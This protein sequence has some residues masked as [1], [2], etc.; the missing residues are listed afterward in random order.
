MLNTYDHIYLAPHLDDVVLSCGGHIY[1]LTQAGESVLIVTVTAG[2]PPRDGLPPFA[3]AH[4]DSWGLDHNAVADRRAEDRAACAILGADWSH[5]TVKDAIY[6]RAPASGE[7][8][9]GNDVQ[10]F[11]PVHSAETPLIT[12]IAEALQVLP[13]AANVIGPL[14]IGNHVDHQLTR[15]AAEAAYGNALA[16]YEDYPYVQWHGMGDSV[17]AT[18]VSETLPVSAEA[19]AKK[20]AAIDAYVSQVDHLFTDSAEMSQRVGDYVKQVN[21]ERLWRKKRPD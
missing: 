5:L 8:L 17:D 16:Y 11:G 14:C 4:H 2:D 1:A 10:L 18:W 3:Q 20:V 12:T 6:R 9:Y 19:L 15:A 21:G 13:P 7:A